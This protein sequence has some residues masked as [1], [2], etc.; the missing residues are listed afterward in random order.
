MNRPPSIPPQWSTLVEALR[1]RTQRQPE[2]RV[3][4]FLADGE[5]DERHLT[6]A[7][8]D[9]RARAIG[10]ELQRRVPQ[11]AR[12]LLLYAPGLD[13]I[14]GF[15][16]CLYAGVVAVPL[17]PPKATQP[18][19]A[20]RLRG[21]VEDAQTSVVLSTSSIIE[22][23]S[24]LFADG[25]R[26][27]EPERIP[28]DTLDEQ[29][30][31]E[32]KNPALTAADLAFLQYT[33]GSTAAPKGVML[34]HANLLHNSGLIQECFGMSAESR[35]VIWLPPYH[36]MGL[37]GG[38]IQPLYAGFQA[39]L[40]SPQH[41][42]QRPV[43]WL[44]AISHYRATTSGGP[45]FAYEL[46]VRKISAEQRA[47]LD[48]SSWAVAFNGAE[49]IRP[50]TLTQFTEAFAPSGF[51]AQSFSP[52]Y[53]LAEAT[54]LVTGC[55]ADAPPVVRKFQEQ[56]IERDETSTEHIFQAA[57]NEDGRAFVGCGQ[58]Q[59]G[60]RVL[61]VNPT[62]LMR[63][64]LGQVG[65]IWVGGP[66]VTRGYWNKPDETERVF[67]A[68][69]ADDAN[70]SED[71]LRTGDL[72][73]IRDGELFITGRLKDLIIIRGRNLYPQDIELT[74]ESCSPMLRPGCGA[75]F[76]ISL[77]G[78][79]RLV[80]VQEVERQHRNVDVEALA[81]I[82]R[83]AV[84]QQHDVQPY[85]VALLRPG[86]IHKTSSGKIQRYAC[87]ESFLK[88]SLQTLGCSIVDDSAALIELSSLTRDALFAHPSHERLE[89]LQKYIRAQVASMKGVDPARIDA[90]Q[91]LLALGLDSLMAIE[92]QH[93]LEAGLGLHL[94]F[95]DLLS[96]M[97]INELVVG[98]LDKLDD[99]VLVLPL[100]SVARLE[101]AAQQPLN[102]GQRALWYLQQVAPTSAAYNI[103]SAMRTRSAFDIQ[104]LQRALR[105]L[106]ER[107]PALQTVFT[108]QGG[109]P[110]QQIRAD[111]SAIL[112]VE[113][114]AEW[115]EQLLQERL[116]EIAHQPF[117]LEQGPLFRVHLFKR[118]EAEQVLLFVFHHII[119]DFWSIAVLARDLNEAYLFAKDGRTPRLPPLSLQHADYVRWQ[120]ELLDG[121]TGERLWA[122]WRERLSGE[123]PVL[124]IPTD[125]PRPSTQTFN[126]AAEALRLTPD[127]TR[128]L[129]ELSSAQGAT[130]YMTVLAAFQVLLSRHSG[131]PDILVGSP[132]SGRS[133]VDF[134]NLV[135]Y[136]VN[137]L[138][139]RANVDG[140]LSFR[141][142]LKQVK[143]TVLE[144][145]E[146][147]DFPFALL[148]ER[149]Q[150][151]RDPS[152]TP[153]FQ[154]MLIFQQTPFVANA[155]L[156]LFGLGETGAEMLVG[157][158]PVE[159][160]GLK[161]RTAQFDLTLAVAEAHGSLHVSLQY[162]TDLFDAASM[163]RMLGHFQTI[164]ESSAL[165]IDQPIGLLQILTEHEREQ[166]L[167]NWNETSPSVVEADL[168]ASQHR[169]IHQLFEAQA[170]R[171]P[172]ATALVFNDVELSFEELNRRANQLAHH[173][174]RM[175]IGPDVPVAIC[176]ERSTDLMVGL[177]GIMKAGGA[178]VPLDPNYPQERLLF[179]LADAGA[180][181]LVTQ[182]HFTSLFADML[183]TRSLHVVC[184]DSDE[185]QLSSEPQVNPASGA[186]AENLAYI[187]YTSGSTGT[188]KG[189]MIEH[190]SVVNFFDAMDSAVGC[191]A[192]DTLLAVTSI[193][194]DISVLELFWT[195][196]R[197]A[198][199][200][201]LT[202]RASSE[203]LA[204]SPERNAKQIQFSLFYFASDSIESQA[205]RYRLVLEGAKFADR[206][207]FS[208]VW[209]PERHFHEFG[210]LYPNPA[211]LSATLAGIT[212]QIQIRAGSV[213][214]PLHD[215]I[216]VAEEWALIDNLSN[217]RVGVA[218]ASGWHA[219]DFVFFP[220]NYADRKEIM[221]RGIETVQRL[222]QGEAIKVRGGAG[223]ELE[224]KTFPRP[225]QPRLPIWIT[226]AG[227]PET[228]I[229]A[230][231]L[232]AGVLT[233]LL[234]Q[235]VED[236]AEKVRAYR[237]ALEAHGHDPQLGHV[238]L[239]LHTFIGHDREAVRQTVQ[240]PFTAYL[241]SSISLIEN[242]IKS[243]N[244]SLDLRTMSEQDMKDLLRF[245]FD[246]YFETSAL[247][248]TPTS[249]L[250]LIEQLKT[251]GIDEIAC[252]IDF[253]VATNE[254]L[255]HL[256][257]L[258]V[259][260]QE[261]N[262]VK[263][264]ADYSLPAQALRYNATMMQCTPSF[265]RMLML[266]PRTCD[267][268]GTLRTLLLGGEALPVA[269]AQQTKEKFSAR[270]INMYG[271]T[272]TTIWSTTHELGEIEK[273]IPIGQP[274]LN[275][276]TYILDSYL[277]PVPVGIAGEL[278]I[279][280]DGLAR[281]YLNRPE[282]TA[283][284]FIPDPFGHEPG[285]RLY[286][287][288][289]VVRYRADGTIEY[290]GRTDHQVKLHGFRIELP[291]IEV[292]LGRHAAVREA[293]AIVREDQP[294]DKRLVAYVVP[295][296][297][298]KPNVSELQN[299]VRE[300]LP[301]YM[302]PSFI[303]VLEALPL[304]ANGKV[305]R[306]KLPA[307]ERTRQDG[308]AG[309][310]APQNK[311]EQTIA[312]I[313]Q[314]ALQVEQIGVQDNFFDRGGHSLLMAQVQS[315]LQKS[316]QRDVPLI[317]L[318][319]HPTIS[320]LAAHLRQQELAQ[321]TF[322]QSIDRAQRQLE[323]RR[324]A[325]LVTMSKD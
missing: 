112:E 184:M 190:R 198:R 50:E 259:L 187:I 141:S 5:A 270:V 54:L 4:T 308:G 92:L 96:D 252:L 170:A 233:H 181:V 248:G 48:L 77:D 223:N 39:I 62:T 82:I 133:R 324:R 27:K 55:S 243:L 219:D 225:V 79:D 10:A 249:C 22:A 211:V 76:S 61:I 120:N 180:P 250:P 17:Y 204:I 262:T 315:Q 123:L 325:R 188:P 178:Y 81:E 166:L 68:R 167:I 161:Q 121:A 191:N 186:T 138:V 199:V 116:Q 295:R 106:V 146:H 102:Y 236:V 244:L 242:L 16:G 107:H 298:V 131:S 99:E 13:Y 74:V 30:A 300:H 286:R 32:W 160:I 318:L 230:G 23:A 70:E 110:L 18:D 195:L 246:R 25:D 14:A 163:Q 64:E 38:I 47:T 224:V 49:P 137:P 182:S 117:D 173:L 63:C 281:G 139:L 140:H 104:H 2:Q 37:I 203:S 78:A 275:T 172:T 303:V 196:T 126:G 24:V 108:A 93:R 158:V 169:C 97:S 174:R 118:S 9:Q 15:F 153:V 40:M 317:T 310:V 101:A 19:R 274:I 45:N 34:T 220:E 129:K 221:F 197:G 95:A 11:G 263:P 294:G 304:T 65:E 232:G 88:G 87:R 151:V 234:G 214:M 103:V 127:L 75:A 269:L 218:F 147:Q 265:M 136:F 257:D 183:N 323:S 320:S 80:V 165:D 222:W 296:A 33:S 31:D 159:S 85:A 36:D 261:A 229:K 266:S 154:A 241:R 268:L 111:L 251:I 267:A 321:P 7:E 217:G 58:S 83:Q 319:E 189:V 113:D 258:A 283:E 53:G 100:Q 90:E 288:G 213:V 279:G 292:V 306:Q 164:L 91:P 152:R 278:Y 284:R 1:W 176:V 293:V 3:Y 316:L 260:R 238:T 247:F 273:T 253:G 313:W 311:L 8:L 209:T 6:F 192:S 125:R 302:I 194:F 73:F 237:E 276:Q 277:Q 12:A 227:H 322:Q 301:T 207:G 185:Q 297:G 200:V 254:V 239:M 309:Y 271:P 272:E 119:S 72:G 305:D 44:H 56:A 287:T 69:L 226:A 98:L 21:V 28:T 35:T 155:D 130:L 128:A 193:S 175:G 105:H 291:E 149:L 71:F 171:T 114:A 157:D 206:H 285:G 145:F 228:F 290:I 156:T 109:E 43:R 307:L 235:S 314:Q 280:G 208:A 282:L 134:A 240:E 212:E 86:S 51:R 215:P 46:C 256:N 162:N 94:P 144:A 210:G 122:Y 289:D 124:N 29:L 299:Y 179:M 202:E 148:A 52:C 150:P 143:Q 132:V 168:I 135:G 231:Q 142:F 177:L 66:S 26:S 84:V 205:A 201:L 216:R 41:F 89:V 312:S 245:A 115:S 59:P 67:H 57:E 42:L 264:V 20:A 60:Q 255:A